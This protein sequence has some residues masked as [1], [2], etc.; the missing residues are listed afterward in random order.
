[1]SKEKDVSDRIANNTRVSL[2]H[3]R[4]SKKVSLTKLKG[5]RQRMKGDKD[6]E[7][8]KSQMF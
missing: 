3:C 4:K 5:M 7:I 1:M 8:G 2:A 6:G